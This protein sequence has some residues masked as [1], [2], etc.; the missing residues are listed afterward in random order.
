MD[1]QSI[2]DA[3]EEEIVSD[4]DF[5]NN[6]VDPDVVEHSE[7]DKCTEESG[8]SPDENESNDQDY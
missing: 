3:L 6:N 5:S 2:I 8:L 7:H 1:Q 4:D